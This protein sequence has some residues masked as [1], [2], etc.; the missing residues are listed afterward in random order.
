MG[1]AVGVLG[2]SGGVGASTLTAAIAM[3]ARAV[4]DGCRTAV[5]VDL[6]LH[7]GLDTVLCIEHLEGLR[8]Q[9]LETP[10][11]GAAGAAGVPA[12]RDLPGDDGVFVL[13]SV[14][15]ELP[16]WPAVVDIV[17]AVAQES[18]LLVVDCGARP[19][20]SVLSR[21]DLLV[22]LARLSVKG[23]ADAVGATSVCP[24]ARTRTVL[25]SRGTPDRGH[26]AALARRL[27]MPFLAHLGD[28]PDIAMQAGRGVPPG[29]ARSGL[30]PV[31]DAVLGLLESTWL[32]SLIGRLD[33]TGSA[34]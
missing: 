7:G 25:V 28:D 4:I 30:D 13:S 16:G 34:G 18:D 1:L 12:L 27:A 3:R 29:T 6:D 31:A 23:A 33:G 19:H 22:V 21:L 11:W 10:G 5:A 20:G 9:D 14:A 2:A 24:L 26:G 17:D 15:G 32:S 8:W